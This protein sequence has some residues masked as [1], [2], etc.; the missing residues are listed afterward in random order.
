MSKD[1]GK[2][3]WYEQWRS[4][5]PIAIAVTASAVLCTF[6]VVAAT[7][8][9]SFI[10]FLVVLGSLLLLAWTINNIYLLLYPRQ[11]M[12]NTQSARELELEERIRELKRDADRAPEAIAATTLDL[13]VTQQQKEVNFVTTQMHLATTASALLAFIA[14]LGPVLCL[15]LY[16]N[17]DLSVVEPSSV[18]SATDMGPPV[19]SP[20]TD[21]RSLVPS[22]RDWR[23][24]G[25]GGSISVVCLTSAGLLIQ[26]VKT[27]TGRRESSQ[28]LM[29]RYAAMATAVKL[30]GQQ[31]DEAITAVTGKVISGLV[32]DAFRPRSAIVE[33]RS[34]ESADS[35][36]QSVDLASVPAQLEKIISELAKR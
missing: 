29:D 34:S 13:A 24:L 5:P 31:G 12:S 10:T 26:L 25:A 23:I 30:S 19:A 28:E 32:A 3:K 9:L 1:S 8:G 21:E 36:V 35:G 2:N 7:T 16:K 18:W 33:K 4:W 14:V 22:D 17:E 27:Q 15:Y 20:A 11:R 6:T